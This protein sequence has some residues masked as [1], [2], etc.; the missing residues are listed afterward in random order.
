MAL[1]LLLDYFSSLL[2]WSL[3]LPNSLKRT[4][5][6]LP[7]MQPVNMTNPHFT[8]PF[9]AIVRGMLTQSDSDLTN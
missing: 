2:S 7:R 1:V 9:G 3:N 4:Y 6:L 8:L 5:I